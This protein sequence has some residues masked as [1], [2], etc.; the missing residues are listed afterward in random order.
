MT[1]LDFLQ[2]Q[3]SRV[4]DIAREAGRRIVEIKNS[5]SIH[6]AKKSD[7]SPVTAADL[8]ASELIVNGLNNLSPL[9]P[10]ISEER[11][12][13]LGS[14]AGLYWLVDPL[15]GTREFI[16]GSM[17]YTVNIALVADMKPVFGVIVVPETGEVF[18]GGKTVVAFRS[19]AGANRV[20]LKTRRFNNSNPECLI[21]SSH[22]SDEEKICRQIFEKLVV[23]NVGSS[24]KYTH[25]ARGQSDFS[26]R[27]TPTSIWDTAA[28]HAILLAAGGDM[29]GPGGKR[30][31]YDPSH[32]EN[33]P[34]I[35]VGDT[36]F[37]W[38]RLITFLE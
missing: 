37:D 30:L 27:K 21:S 6:V 9:I 3:A 12:I 35:A 14:K 18:V 38:T 2:T 29:F 4:I 1:Q 31:T 28:A 34:F 25:I 5:T 26:F 10:V 23:K 33:P 7:E 15:D 36:A 8:A 17:E 19:D 20:D 22:K 32:L 11:V 13:E 24:L 16:K